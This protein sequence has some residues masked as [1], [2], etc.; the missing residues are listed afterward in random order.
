MKPRNSMPVHK[1][2]H[3]IS[4][5]MN[6]LQE[7]NT[8]F[9]N[10]NTEL[11]QSIEDLKLKLNSLESSNISEL[12]EQIFQEQFANIQNHSIALID[13]SLKQTLEKEIVYS[14]INQGCRS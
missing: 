7:Q 9:K 13:N 14:Y 8:N 10:E 11:K 12:I 2:S 3:S 6:F 1:N 5:K 4:E